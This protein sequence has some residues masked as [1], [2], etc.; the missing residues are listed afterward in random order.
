MHIGPQQ[1]TDEPLSSFR[2]R[3]ARYC[4]PWAAISA[5]V[6][7]V[8]VHTLRTGLGD[9]AL[10][11]SM[12]FIAF[13]SGAIL[14]MALVGAAGLSLGARWAQ[15]CESSAAFATGW[16]RARFIIASLFLIPLWLF[17]C[18]WTFIA[19]TQQRILFGR[20]ARL[21]TLADEPDAFLF[22]LVVMASSL[23]LIP[24]YWMSEVR[25]HLR[26]RKRGL[27]VSDSAPRWDTHSRPASKRLSR[28][29]PQLP[30]QRK[31]DTDN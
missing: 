1:E 15:L 11:I 6:L 7:F 20:P 19:I 5:P 28:Q 8:S 22:S 30:H 21:V 25:K 16:Q 31:L 27:V 12:V 13:F 3:Q 23:V 29:K 10:W 9:D 26:P 14:G 4:W 24:T 17:E 18:Y 2:Y